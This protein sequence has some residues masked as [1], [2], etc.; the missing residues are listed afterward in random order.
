[1]ASS[2]SLV[3]ARFVPGWAPARGS[4]ARRR[5]RG[6]RPRRSRRSAGGRSPGTGRSVPIRRRGRS[7]PPGEDPR[8]AASLART[9]ASSSRAAAAPRASRPARP[10]R[11]LCALERGAGTAAVAVGVVVRAVVR[12]VVG[13]VGRG[14][15]PGGVWRPPPRGRW[16]PPRGWGATASAPRSAASSEAASRERAFAAAALFRLREYV[17]TFAS[18]ARL[19]CARRRRGHREARVAVRVSRR[20]R[21]SRRHRERKRGARVGGGRTPAYRAVADPRER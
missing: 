1:M 11:R 19:R 15:A 5:E 9:A 18:L 8:C 2:H 20:E 10:W 6:R 17:I 7:R 14:G 16:T 4:Q 13:E 3:S 12:A 21:G